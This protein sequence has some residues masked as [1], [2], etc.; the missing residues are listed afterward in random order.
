MQFAQPTKADAML[1][2]GTIPNTASRM[3]TAE[4]IVSLGHGLRGSLPSIPGTVFLLSLWENDL[5]GHLHELRL[6]ENGTLL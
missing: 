3:T 1:H 6:I 5:E 2:Q 4:I